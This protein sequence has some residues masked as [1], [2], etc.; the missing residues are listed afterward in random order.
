MGFLREGE[1]CRQLCCG[2]LLALLGVVTVQGYRDFVSVM[3]ANKQK[4]AQTPKLQQAP[5]VK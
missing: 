2:H 3:S 5:I 1:M 4:N